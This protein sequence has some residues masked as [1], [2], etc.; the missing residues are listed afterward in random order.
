[1][2]FEVFLQSNLNGDKQPFE[3][4]TWNEAERRW[5]YSCICVVTLM[6]KIEALGFSCILRPSPECCS[7]PPTI[8]VLDQGVFFE[9]EDVLSLTPAGELLAEHKNLAMKMRG[10]WKELLNSPDTLSSA[11]FFN[12]LAELCESCGAPSRWGRKEPI[13]CGSTE[14]GCPLCGA[15]RGD[16]CVKSCPSLR[17][18]E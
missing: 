10:V 18:G 14:Y 16:E 8:E 5:E 6:E 4:C 11:K 15:K 3:G 1:M 12:V 9:D 17:K 2:I 13:P 7:D